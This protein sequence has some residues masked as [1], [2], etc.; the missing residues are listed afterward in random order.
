VLIEFVGFSGAGKSTIVRSAAEQLGGDARSGQELPGG[1][2][3][4]AKALVSNPPLTAWC[5]MNGGQVQRSQ[6]LNLSRRDYRT[7][8]LRD[9][10]GIH[11]IDNSSMH[12]LGRLVI[13]GASRGEW[14]AA[15][16]VEPDVMVLV[17]VD[18]VVGLRRFR[19]RPTSHTDHRMDDAT[20]VTRHG[21][22]LAFMERVAELRNCPTVRI[23]TSLDGDHSENLL[24]Q[25]GRYASLRVN[26]E[27]HT[28]P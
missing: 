2:R 11:L 22:Y 24:A 16:M 6:L 26:A 17:T 23:D 10:P 20:I 18:P 7:R 27:D 4:L 5:A 28:D 19:N 3:S 12:R 8:L 14:A 13:A 15:K 1:H 9:V 25:V 21:Q